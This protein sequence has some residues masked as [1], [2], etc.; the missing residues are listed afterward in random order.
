MSCVYVFVRMCVYEYVCMHVHQCV[1]VYV[2]M[3]D[4]RG[5]RKGEAG[6]AESMCVCMYTNVCMCMCAEGAG[7]RKET[8]ERAQDRK[9]RAYTHTYIHI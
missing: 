3:C 5:M 8:V 7:A 1:Y 2:C 9:T 6:R 4:Y